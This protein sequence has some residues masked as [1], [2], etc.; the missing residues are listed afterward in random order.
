MA[1]YLIG[2][3]KYDNMATFNIGSPN[4]PF[5]IAEN[6]NELKNSAK[7]VI[8]ND[9]EAPYEPN[10]LVKEEESGMY[11][12]IK[13]DTSEFIAIDS[14]E[15]TYI[16]RHTLDL[17]DAMEYLNFVRVPPCVFPQNKYTFEN[18]FNRLFHISNVDIEIA[19]ASYPFI[20]KD[21]NMNF[22]SFDNN[23]QLSTAINKIAAS[24]MV[25]P[26]LF[27]NLGLQVGFKPK[28]GIAAPLGE[29]NTIFPDKQRKGMSNK[30]QYM[31]RAYSTLKN[32]LNVEYVFYP[33]AFGVHA[34]DETS[35]AFDGDK[36]FI[37]MPSKIDNVSY[38]QTILPCK[39]V[40]AKKSAGGSYSEEAVGATETY[41]NRTETEWLDFAL[42]E[43]ALFSTILEADIEATT[44][45]SEYGVGKIEKDN[46]WEATFNLLPKREYSALEVSNVT[47]HD[48]E[49]TFYW[50]S[51]GN[52][53]YV[54]KDYIYPNSYTKYL[55][56]EIISKAI[57]ETTD[58]E[59]LII[60][61]YNALPL[62]TFF[63][64]FYRPIYDVFLSYDNE[65]EAQ[66]ERPHNQ[67]GSFLDGYATSKSLNAYAQE[68]I[69]ISLVRYKEFSTFASIYKCGD[70]VLVSGIPYLINQ[71]SIDCYKGKYLCIFN[72]SKSKSAR[73]DNVGA[74]TDILDKAIPDD[75]LV[76][77]VQIYKD[78][79]EIEVATSGVDTRHH[80]TAYYEALGYKLLDL[81][82]I[83]DDY[84]AIGFPTNLEMLSVTYDDTDTLIDRVYVP[85]IKSQFVKSL[86]Y[87]ADFND[88][89]I[90]GIK[91]SGTNVQTPIRYADASANI[92][93]IDNY[94][95]TSEQLKDIMALSDYADLPQVSQTII[96]AVAISSATY[97]IH[98]E[99]D[100]YDKSEY[101]IPVFQYHIE[102]N[103]ASNALA[104]VNVA[105]NILNEYGMKWGT[106]FEGVVH[107]Y[108]V[109]S[110]TP[111]TQENA[112]ERWD[113]LFV[114]TGKT[115]L[116]NVVIVG[117][118]DD[119]PSWTNDYLF[120]L[121][122]TFSSTYNATALQNKC[123]G[124]YAVSASL[125]M[126][127]PKYLM[128]LNFYRG[129]SNSLIP[130]NVNNWKI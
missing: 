55:D 120:A 108:Y 33:N 124:I 75:N 47:N 76:K 67:D 25:V 85:M 125:T 34:I 99:D 26:Y 69:G 48:Q 11:F 111:I 24:L 97:A 107:Y 51:K 10:T 79:L 3:D 105:D 22:M 93:H 41:S 52:K 92:L 80:D 53:I 64:V 54:P 37:S 8:E 17:T 63:R 27:Y 89:Y 121:Y 14:D 116:N 126:T 58:S 4:L 72:L 29:I 65:S 9:V 2:Y 119:N 106:P 39:I 16:Y 13:G 94:I 101:E 102:V 32:V 60:R 59:V 91:H 66:D 12:V 36:S 44:F 117:D 88:N 68:S 71:R 45:P 35:L 115:T 110:D 74:N 30:D 109:I 129:T 49:N 77:R 128:S 61:I 73:D 1:H 56:Y 83:E 104:N 84:T 28:Y 7:C 57:P 82:R 96:D 78:Y 50:E 95:I 21:A 114:G 20:N 19:W 100:E 112:Q 42:N 103:G 87:R 118:S 90:I 40:R 127:T 130:I 6:I 113:T 43:S 70:V 15:V 86:V 18:A 81:H 5:D 31:T 62:Y 38:I 46:D 23:Y 98:I 123:I 122:S